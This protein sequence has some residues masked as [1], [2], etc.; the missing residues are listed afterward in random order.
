M[1]VMAPTKPWFSPDSWKGRIWD[2]QVVSLSTERNLGTYL[3]LYRV[4]LA[5]AELCVAAAG[6]QVR[7]RQDGVVPGFLCEWQVLW[8]DALPP[9]GERLVDRV[10]ADLVP[11][12]IRICETIPG[13]QDLDDAEGGDVQLRS[14]CSFVMKIPTGLSTESVLYRSARPR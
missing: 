7:P 8:Q 1:S 5:P 13:Q 2:N 6:R 3:E 12:G 10:S 9:L 14:P 11:T 4:A